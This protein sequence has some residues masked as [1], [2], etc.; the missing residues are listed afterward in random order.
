[1][2]KIW[3]FIRSDFYRYTGSASITKMLLYA[4]MAKLPGF[5]YSFYFRLASSHNKMV[6][7]PAKLKLRHLKRLYNIDIAAGTKVG[8]GLFLGHGMSIVV[9]AKT[10]I[11]N[12]VN[13]SH[14][15][16]IGTNS[17]R[18]AV[19]GNNVYIGPNVCIVDDVNIGDNATI[20]AGSVVV[21]DIPCAA[22]A[23]GAPCRPVNY[24]NPG[25]FICNRWTI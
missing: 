19:I 1:M 24:N 3:L 23:V 2:A 22:T 21:H 16:S 7:I 4:L 20:G 12:N 11:G 9:N 25:R 5:T 8:Y 6:S 13:L 15:V 17:N 14:F 18:P 10:I